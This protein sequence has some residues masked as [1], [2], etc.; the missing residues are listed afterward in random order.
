[1]Q[2]AAASALFPGVMFSKPS[3]LHTT[4]AGSSRHPDFTGRSSR[5]WWHTGNSCAADAALG[6][7]HC[8]QTQSG[9]R[10]RGINPS[11]FPG[12]FAA[13][14]AA[15]LIFFVQTDSRSCACR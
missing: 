11:P 2:K 15:F 1:M 3:K 9:K 6:Y 12:K 14:G 13:S 4:A 5:I 7:R 10:R 8:L